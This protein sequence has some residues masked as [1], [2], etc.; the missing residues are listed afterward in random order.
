[1]LI[2]NP[3][4]KMRKN[5]CNKSY[6]QFLSFI[7]VHMYV[8]QYL[9]FNWFRADFFTSFNGFKMSIEL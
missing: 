8:Q 5:S 7:T 9:T 2:S 1:M 3:L 4:K 6:R